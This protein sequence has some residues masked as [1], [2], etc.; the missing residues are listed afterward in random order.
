MRITQQ[1]GNSNK[2]LIAAAAVV[3]V[4]L[5]LI[6]GVMLPG[7]GPSLPAARTGPG[8]GSQVLIL[9]LPA[10]LAGVVSFLSPCTL[11]ILPAYF[12]F[13]FAAKRQQVALMTL[14]FFMGLATTLTVLG[15][16]FSLLGSLAHQYR[17]QL[18]T[19]GGLLII[20]LGVMSLLGKGFSGVRMSERPAATF[21]GTYVYGMTFAL[22]WTACI[23]PILG[24][25]LTLLVA[26]G[27]SGSVLAG[28]V[29]A[30]IYALGLA[31]PLFLVALFFSKIGTGTRFWRIMKGRGWTV[32]LLGR[33]LHLHSTSV[34]SGIL[35]MGLGALLASGQLA[36]L[37][38]VAAGSG[39]PGGWLQE[40]VARL[41]G[42]GY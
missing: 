22:G 19:I 10:F 1:R 28:M 29:L 32:H 4:G 26:Q 8:A 31:L 9:A 36:Y 35:L 14:A 6:L 34:I 13:T 15:A 38:A 20:G 16:G 27:G 41:F 2:R 30:F 21:A 12:A 17:D 42:V 40:Q 24:A 39:D 25:L 33:E 3:G 7:D 18:T 5:L 37:S 11:P 23:G